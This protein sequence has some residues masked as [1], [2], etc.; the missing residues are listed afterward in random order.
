MRGDAKYTK[1]TT[2]ALTK[3][4]SGV[5]EIINV[6]QQDTSSH[7][8]EA[9]QGHIGGLSSAWEGSLLPGAGGIES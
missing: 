7:G 1:M 5:R 6:T 9:G 2:T 3:P 4:K 8:G